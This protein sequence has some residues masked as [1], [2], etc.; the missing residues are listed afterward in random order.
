LAQ[1]DKIEGCSGRSNQ[2][3]SLKMCD[4]E[5]NDFESEHASTQSVTGGRSLHL[6]WNANTTGSKV[7]RFFHNVLTDG[8][9][10]RLCLA[11]VPEGERRRDR[12]VW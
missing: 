10:S 9:I 2:F 8:P 5:T 12:C 1:W 4:D 11:T 3:T 6:N 7:I